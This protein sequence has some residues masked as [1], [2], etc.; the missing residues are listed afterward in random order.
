MQGGHAAGIGSSRRTGSPFCQCRLEIGGKVGF[1]QT[2][3][4]TWKLGPRCRM[5]A[6]I[7]QSSPG[8]VRQIGDIELVERM[9]IAY[10]AHFFHL[11]PREDVALQRFSAVVSEP[12]THRMLHYCLSM[13][14]A[15][16]RRIKGVS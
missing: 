13:L 7:R 16:T 10:V 9:L 4:L 1:A 15:F 5:Y 8:S 6:G 12:A 11:L 14:A 2:P 3:K